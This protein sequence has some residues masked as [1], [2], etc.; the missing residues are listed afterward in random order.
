MG[1][2]VTESFKP[3]EPSDEGG[4][5]YEYGYDDRPP[6]GRILWGRVAILGGALI[7]AFL[8]GRWLAPSGG[9]DAE[10]LADLRG[11]IEELEQTNSDLESQLDEQTAVETPAP[12]PTDTPAEGT[13]TGTAATY[14]VQ[15]GDT[16]RLI[17]QDLCGDPEAADLIMELN[18]ITDPTQLSVGDTL[19]LPE[20]CS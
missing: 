1:D 13:D 12:T 7:L 17:A 16:L 10:E 20:E 6:G 19:T 3:Y 9:A 14:T 11:Q 8:L 15:R 4:Y 2:R 18:G 5:E